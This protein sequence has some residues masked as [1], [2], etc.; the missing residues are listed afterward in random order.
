MFEHESRARQDSGG[1][2]VFGVRVYPRQPPFSLLLPNRGAP[3][4]STLFGLVKKERLHTFS[5]T[6]LQRPG[7]PTAALFRSVNVIVKGEVYDRTVY[8]IS[9]C[10]ACAVDV[11]GRDLDV[12]A[13]RSMEGVTSRRDGRSG[14]LP[15]HSAYK[16]P[17]T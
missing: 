12:S 17:D 14:L 3:G 9:C 7:N 1:R 6:E 8:S 2:N 16:D 4:R 13:S 10:L 5:F 15:L 11:V